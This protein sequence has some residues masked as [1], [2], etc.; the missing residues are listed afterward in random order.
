[1]FAVAYVPSEEAAEGQKA[2]YIAALNITVS[3]VPARDN[4]S[5]STTQTA[6]TGKGGEESGEE[7]ARKVLGACGRE[8][9]NENCKLL[10][11]FAEDYKLALLTTLFEFPKV[12]VLHLR[13]RQPQQRTSM[14]GLYMS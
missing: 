7:A 9:L 14:S 2:K 6:R 3:S 5:F 11:A 13:K 1:M 8:M 10:L 4:V 12:R